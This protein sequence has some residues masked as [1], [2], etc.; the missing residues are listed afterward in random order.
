MIRTER[1]SV[2]Q[3]KMTG[4]QNNQQQKKDG[5]VNVIYTCPMHPEVMKDKPGKCTKCK[6]K[7][8]RKEVTETL[9]TCP[10]HPD[11]IQGKEGKCPKCKMKLVKKE[12]AIKADTK[13]T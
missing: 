1:N 8:V 4:I 13:K 3:D 6:M 11:V 2:S 7:L 10:M 5:A 9:Y 12:P